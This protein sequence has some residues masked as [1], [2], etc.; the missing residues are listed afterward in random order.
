MRA[1]RSPGLLG[2]STSDFSLCHSY[3][4]DAIGFWHRASM[5]SRRFMTKTTGLSPA[6]AAILITPLTFNLG[7]TGNIGAARIGVRVLTAR[8]QNC[9]TSHGAATRG[10]EQ[11]LPRRKP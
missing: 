1:G 10:R 6:S 9:L 5:T 4:R 2:Y 11:S 3:I 7:S 8:K